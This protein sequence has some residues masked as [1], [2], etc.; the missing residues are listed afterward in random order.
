M[1]AEADLAQLERTL[2]GPLPEDGLDPRTVLAALVED[3]AP[4]VVAIPSG[5]YFGFVI[6]GGVPAALAADW[7][8]ATWD[9]NAGLFAISPAAA[10]VEEV[11]CWRRRAGTWRATA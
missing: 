3:A 1:R 4:G 2:G 10:V 9:Q 7:L 5:R 6:G 8:T 11:W